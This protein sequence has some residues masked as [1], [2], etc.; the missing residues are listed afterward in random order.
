MC[1]ARTAHLLV[2]AAGQM[3]KKLLLCV[4]L[5]VQWESVPTVVFEPL[6]L[7]LSPFAPHVA[8]EL[9]ERLG[10]TESLAYQPWPEVGNL[11]HGIAQ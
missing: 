11:K 1:F 3:C 2:L 9:W 6:V 4:C 7:L 5:W 8:E 10:H